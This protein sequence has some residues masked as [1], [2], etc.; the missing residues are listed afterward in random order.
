M[1]AAPLSFPAMMTQNGSRHWQMFPGV[2]IR[3]P[4]PT[5]PTPLRTLDRDIPW[6]FQSSFSGVNFFFPK[7]RLIFGYH[8]LPSSPFWVLR[9]TITCWL[10]LPSLTWSFERKQ[11]LSSLLHGGGLRG[12]EYLLLCMQ[13][14]ILWTPSHSFRG[15]AEN[16]PAIP[17]L[18]LSL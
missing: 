4:P 3:S 10:I 17:V 7:C 15:D 5:P 11:L 8:W 14:S 1:P 9:Y 6:V 18:T 16:P 13:I 2:K 12:F